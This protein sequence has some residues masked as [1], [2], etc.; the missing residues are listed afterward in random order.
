MIKEGTRVFCKAFEDQPEQFGEALGEP[1]NGVIVVVVD[2]QE[3]PLDDRIR[4]VPIDQ[5]VEVFE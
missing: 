4:E 5:I 2:F 1:E 3:D